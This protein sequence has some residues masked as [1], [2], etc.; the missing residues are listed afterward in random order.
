MAVNYASKYASVVDER[1]KLGSLTTGIINGNFEWI[2]VKTVNV[3]SRD[4]ATLNDYKTTGSNRYGTPDELGN[5]EQEM[6][7]T[8]DKSFT[9]TIDAASE[10]DTN[11]TM[12]AAATLAENIDNLVIP[13]MDTYRLSVIAANAPASGTVSGKTHII[14]KAV[15]KDNAFEEFLACQEVLDDDKAPQGGR[16]AVVTPSYLNKIK[17]D[18]N[19]TKWGDMAQKMMINGIVGVIDGV[20]A[21]KVPASYLPE[22]VD[23][24]IT[25]PL[26]APGPV[27]LQEFKINYNAPG[28]SGA[29][30][31]AR[32]RYDCFVLEKK[33]D[34]IAV[35]KSAA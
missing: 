16:I 29:L 14:T 24:L 35:H 6:T 31:E 2:G 12:E 15:T 23:F 28:I 7:V 3:F 33:K 9:Y 30:V 22:S 18:D 13:A 26:V 5:S 27:K 19:F 4:L 17:L 34:A 25:N 21:I 1:F 10:Q 32:V 20:P 11:G 8:Q